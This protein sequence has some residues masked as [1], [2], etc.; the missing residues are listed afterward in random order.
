MAKVK[1][2]LMSAEVRGKVGGLIFNTARGVKY[3]KCFTSPTQ[4]RT[5]KQLKIRGYMQICTR[6]WQTEEQAVRDAFA[7]YAITHPI[8]D[9]TGESITLSGFNIY[10]QLNARL[11]WMGSPMIDTPPESAAPDAPQGTTAT[12]GVNEIDLT[13]TAYDGTDT[14]VNVYIVGPH[15]PGRQAK[16]EQAVYKDSKNG[17]TGTMTISSLQAGFYTLFLIATSESEGTISPMTKL[18]ATV[19]SA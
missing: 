7:G 17:E 8:I 14:R 2:P 13:W 3:V 12:G 9:W 19:T 18:T 6:K 1:N 5:Q 4:P 15:S 16:F 11:L 10:C